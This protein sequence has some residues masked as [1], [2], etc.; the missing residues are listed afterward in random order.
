MGCLFL[1]FVVVAFAQ[2]A[3]IVI[4]S[5]KSQTTPFPHFWEE[6]IGSGHAALALREDWQKAMKDV[7]DNLGFK[8][9]RFHGLFDDDMNVVL[10]QGYSFYS[11]DQV[12]DYLFSIGVDPLVELSFMPELIASNTSE[13][14]MHYKGIISPPADFE[15]WVDL[16]KTFAE[17]LIER[18]GLDKVRTLN[19]EVWNEYNCG[20]LA[21]KN[22]RQTYYDIFNATSFAL[23]SVDSKLRV[24]GPVTCMSMEIDL[25]LSY[26]EHNNV[27]ADF[28][29]RFCVFGS[30]VFWFFNVFV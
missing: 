10:P 13:T 24:G 1:L 29:S 12:F 19:F 7:H 15:K 21:S 14:I 27:A 16:I 28:I 11:I 5:D 6:C 3:K 30:G 23:K 2:D 17:H 25:F 8:R 26:I 9:V 20:F 4:D 18:Y 22:P